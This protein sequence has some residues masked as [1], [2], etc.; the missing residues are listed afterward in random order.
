[1]LDSPA[2]WLRLGIC[3]LLGTIGGVGLWCAVV[4][5]PTVQAAFAATRAE[6]SLAYT[7]AM[8]GFAFGGI[9]T[10][11]SADRFGMV[12]T[13]IAGAA[14]LAC[15]FLISA[16][17]PS[18]FVYTLAQGL[19]GVGASATFGPLVADVANWFDRRRGLAMA[20]A[21]SGNYLAGTIWPP[22]VQLGI[23]TV[24]WRATHGVIAALCVVVM[25]PLAVALRRSGRPPVAVQALPAGRGSL[26]LRPWA[27]QSA[28]AVAGFA[29]CTAMSMPQVHIVAY[30]GDLGYGPARGAEMLSLMLGFGIVSRVGSG[31]VADRIGGLPTLLLGSVAQMAALLLYVGFN[32]L[33][34]LYLI[35]VLFGLFQGGIVPSYAIIIRAVFPANET[36]TRFGVVLMATI[37]GMAAGGWMSGAI[38]DWT[39]SYRAAFANGVAWNVLNAAI[40]LWLLWRGRMRRAQMVEAVA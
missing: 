31:W 11:R 7:V 23:T 19:A 15:G 12:F 29:C 2:S 27:L 36:G 35:S 39:G 21:A 4:V 37:L 40:A 16:V 20:V 13:A 38:F 30:C 6:A 22:I 34:S 14:L 32:S 3:L 8:V 25:V 18:L 5:L 1:L 10:G 26:G 24:G 9:M 17:A 33:A 28:L